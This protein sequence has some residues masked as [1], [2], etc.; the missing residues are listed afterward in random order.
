[1]A[2]RLFRPDVNEDGT[3]PGAECFQG[4]RDLAGL[5]QHPARLLQ[6]GEE[7]DLALDKL[8][9]RRLQQLSDAVERASKVTVAVRHAQVLQRLEDTVE[10]LGRAGLAAADADAARRCHHHDAETITAAE[11]LAFLYDA[12]GQATGLL[13][14]GRVTRLEPHA[15]RAINDEDS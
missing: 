3:R 15:E 1:V 9:G 5:R 4:G 13:E 11:V 6:I 12:L 10:F 14:A 2:R 8:A 7:V